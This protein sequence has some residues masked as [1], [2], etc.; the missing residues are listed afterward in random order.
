M[1][2]H[3]PARPLADKLNGR[4]ASTPP[5]SLKKVVPIPPQPKMVPTLVPPRRW[6]RF[7]SL[8]EGGLHLLS[9]LKVAPSSISSTVFCSLG[10]L[11]T[12]SP[13]KTPRLGLLTAAAPLAASLRPC[14]GE[15]LDE[16]SRHRKAVQGLQGAVASDA[17]RRLAHPCGKWRRPAA[18]ASVVPTDAS[19][20]EMRT[21]FL[22]FAL[23][24]NMRSFCSPLIS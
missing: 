11:S 12:R 18:A 17:G 14:D 24:C 23:H 13:S 9:Y 15:I 16:A 4:Y 2:A 1:C 8:L 22:S 3:V 10:E 19:V 20:A 5:L 7:S 6:I 21:L